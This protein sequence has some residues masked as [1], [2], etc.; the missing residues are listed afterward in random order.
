MVS[1][2]ISQSPGSDRERSATTDPN[3]IDTTAHKGAQKLFVAGLSVG[4]AYWIAVIRWSK[5]FQFHRSTAGSEYYIAKG[6]VE[7]GVCG[8]RAR[9]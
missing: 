8:I 1:K 7:M 6:T 9:E 2:G 3:R 5:S 4:A